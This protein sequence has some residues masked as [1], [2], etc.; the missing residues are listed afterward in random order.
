M[1]LNV[2]YGPTLHANWYAKP[3]HPNTS[4][5]AAT[6][7]HP[8]SNVSS[9]AYKEKLAVLV[10]EMSKCPQVPMPLKHYFAPGIYVREI[11][12][13]AG[14]YVIGKIHKTQHFNIIQR[15]R[16]SLVN[17][18]GTATEVCGPTTF[19]SGAGVQKAMYI[20]EDTVW[21]TIHLTDERTMESLEAEIIQADDS[22]Q[23]LDRPEE[24]RAIAQAAA[25]E[26]KLL[27]HA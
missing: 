17:E 14:T 11:H 19:V 9:L 13:P 8:V 7:T 2:S 16:L 21:S 5:A 23:K 15:G 10:R 22:Y 6:A 4:I 12:M 24:R 20:H 26:P 3:V 27:E 25:S 18:D 1:E